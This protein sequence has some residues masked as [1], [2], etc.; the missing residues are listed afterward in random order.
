MSNLVPF[1]NRTLAL[2]EASAWLVKADRGLTPEEREQMQ[3]W[4]DQSPLNRQALAEAVAIWDDVDMVSELAEI[5]PLERYAA[6]PQ[7]V[8][9]GLPFIRIGVATAAL[10]LAVTMGWFALDLRNT[11]TV[12][13]LA[14][15]Y[16]TELGQQTAVPLSDGSRVTLNT[17]SQVAIR[18][19]ASERE[20]VLERGEAY[21]EVAH[22]PE[23][24]F[25][26]RTA[27]GT[28][29]AVG[30]AFSV[31][32][33]EGGIGVLVAEGAVTV[34][35]ESSE[36][37]LERVA[38]GELATLDAAGLSLTPLTAVSIEAGLAWRRGMLIFNDEP[39]E[40]A[41]AEFSRYSP[42]QFVFADDAIRRIPVG[43]YFR[44]GDVDG[45]L[46]ALENNFQIRV[47]RSRADRVVLR[48]R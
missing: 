47:E 4:V 41:L 35:G 10:F 39:L 37:A 45:L 20:V 44:V 27:A 6:H 40:L 17:D 5:F 14:L 34:A 1:P 21:F 26:V 38:A 32:L 43:G 36:G 48:G 13:D 46:L 2:E 23:R 9:A 16:G 28:V 7:P 22:D 15:A 24:P 25:R 19:V 8:K 11:E 30:T 31:R 29:T 18:F 42:M 3:R 33:R 12:A